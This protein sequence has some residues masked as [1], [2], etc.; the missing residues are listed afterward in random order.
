MIC[1]LSFQPL[2][3]QVGELQGI[4]RTPRTLQKANLVKLSNTWSN[5]QY[6]TNQWEPKGSLC[7]VS[8]GLNVGEDFFDGFK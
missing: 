3:L 7:Q 6:V 5:Y 8:F 4:R 2:Y 1:V